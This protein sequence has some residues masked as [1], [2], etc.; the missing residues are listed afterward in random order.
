MGSEMCIRD[1][2]ETTGREHHDLDTGR[3]WSEVLADRP[4]TLAINGIAIGVG[5]PDQP[6]IGG[7]YTDVLQQGD[8]SFA[9]YVDSFEAFGEGIKTK[10]VRE[11]VPPPPTISYD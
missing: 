10:L 11:I 6:E 2:F 5:H 9:L 8:N 3:P 1:R 7:W 4:S